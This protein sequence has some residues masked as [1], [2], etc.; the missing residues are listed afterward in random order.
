MYLPPI[1]DLSLYLNRYDSPR[2]LLAWVDF[3]PQLLYETKH[4][5]VATPYHRN[6]A[7]VLYWYDVMTI[8]DDTAAYD[9]IRKRN[10]NMILICPRGSE[11]TMLAAVKEKNNFYNR[12]K[13][14]YYPEWLQPISLPENIKET[15][16]LY[17]VIGGER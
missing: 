16:Y 10:I 7:G 12:L 3:G 8:E 13:A 15:F 14:G 5:V 9:L 2:T 11:N 6:S 1:H 17:E 4:N